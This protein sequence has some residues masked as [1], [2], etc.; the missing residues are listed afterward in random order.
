MT[1]F[2]ESAIVTA[3]G[4]AWRE[5]STLRTVRVALAAVFVG[6][7]LPAPASAATCADYDNQAQA[8]RAADTRDA[9]GDGVYCE[10]LPCPCSGPGSSSP[11]PAPPP[12][13]PPPVPPP[14]PPPS[15]GLGAVRLFR[16]PDKAAYCY[17]AATLESANPVLGCWTP[18]DGFTVTIAHDASPPKAQARYLQR[19]RGRKPGGYDIL[20]FGQ[21]YRWRCDDVG[22]SFA[23]TCSAD[24][25]RTVFR[26]TSRSTGLTCTNRAGHGFHLGRFIGYRLF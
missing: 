12:P 8:Q 2:T 22:R 16:T 11:P 25:A 3:T 10:A 19:N 6:T 15:G 24:A 5:G 4:H 9:D 7:L 18:N 26:C 17:I 21:T 1:F 20:R 14:P 23:E 13:P